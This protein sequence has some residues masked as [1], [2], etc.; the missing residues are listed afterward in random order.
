MIKH[1]LK[2][3]WRNLSR[4]KGLSFINIIG[5]S[6][7]L[8]CFSLF[9]LYAV[10]EFNF[11]RF[12]KNADNIYRVYRWTETMNG[13]EAG[14]DVYM[15]SP[16]GAAMKTDLPDVADFVRL[17]EGW[18]QSFVKVDGEVRRMNVSYADPSFFSVFT[19]PLKYGTAKEALKE[20]QN[21]VIT[22]AKAKELFG[23]D[24][25]VGRTIEIKIDESFVAFAVSA[26]AQNIPA[27]SSIQFGLMGNFNFL[28]TTSGAKRGI[29]NWFR[30]AYQT[31]VQLNPGSGLSND[32]Q[33]L[34]AFHHKYYPTEE[35]ELRKEGF[36]WEGE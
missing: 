24:N 5:L 20:L 32:V 13:E 28:E 18:G 36:K 2:I 23:T 1:Y 8:A 3:A 22:R 15:P 25:V 27:N 35:D 6:L 11:D 12:H 31:Y 14:G 4:Q 19:F 34:A 16:L 21:I 26:V 10:N 7:G 33:K 17:S 30:S 29:N 9:L